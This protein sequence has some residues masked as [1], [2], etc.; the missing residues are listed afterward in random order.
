MKK[1]F[2]FAAMLAMAASCSVSEINPIKEIGKV[3]TIAPEITASYENNGTKTTI[4]TDDEGVGTIWWKPADEI[5]VFY[6][7]T[8]THYVSK[9]K[10]N[11]TTV[12]FGTT[13]IIGS[14]ESAQ[15]NIWGLYPYNEDAVCD[16]ES[17]ITTISAIQKGV[18]GTFDDD[19][20]TSLAHSTSTVMTFYNVLGGIKFS[21]LREDIKKITFK[22]N[23]DE[24]IAG[25]VK[26]EMDANGKPAAEVTEGEKTIIL[27]PKEGTTFAKNTNY[28]IVLLPTVLS[29]GFTMTFET[30][31]A[32]GTFEYTAKSIEI[33][34]SVF[35]KKENLDTYASFENIDY[36]ATPF[37]ISS[38]GSTSVAL[39]K[40]GTPYDITLEYRKGKGSWGAYTIGNSI[41]LGDGEYVQF[42]AGEGGND[43]FSKTLS[44][45]TGYDRINRYSFKS[46]GSGH[47]SV[48][49]NIMSLLDQNMERLSLGKGCFQQ[50]FSKCSHLLDASNL[51]LPA[52]NLDEVCYA[53]MFSGCSSLQTTPELP[54]ANLAEWCYSDMFD[55]CT[56]LQTAP[57]LPATNLASNCYSQMFDGC[58]SLQ[59]APELPATNLAESCYSEMFHGCTSLQTAPELPATTLA[60]Y[61]YSSMFSGCTSLQTAPELPSTNLAYGCYS[62]MFSGCTSLQTAPEL[63]AT[64]LAD[65]CYSSMFRLCSNLETV[66]ELPVTNLVVGCYSSMFN[67]CTSLQTAPELPATNLASHCYSGMFSDC[68]GLQTA[69]ELPST[70]LVVGCYRSMFSGCSSLQTAPELPAIDLDNDCYSKMFSECTG[71]TQAPELPATILAGGCY[72]SMFSGCASLQTAPELPATILDQE[73]YYKMFSGCYKLNYVEAM[74]ETTPSDTY[75]WNW[76][77]GVSSAG[78]F[79][80]SKNAT[81]DVTGPNGIPEGWTIQIQGETNITLDKTEAILVI[82][83]IINLTATVSP[84]D[85]PDKTVTWSSNDETIATVEDGVVTAIMVGS[86]TITAKSGD[87]TATC[88]ITV[89]AGETT[90]PFTI[91]SVGSTSISI[92]EADFPYSIT[93]EYRKGEGSWSA[94]NIGSTISLSDG[95]KVQFIAGLGGNANFSR[96]NK[97]HYKVVVSGS[98]TAKVSGNIM[99]LLEKTGDKSTVPNYAFNH[100]F[101]DCNKLIDASR[102]ELPATNL[103]AG[104][105]GSMFSGC[106]SL[107]TA[108]EL[109]A[110]TLADYCYISMFSVCTSLQTAPELPATNLASGCYSSMFYGC[111]SLQTTPEL[112]AT[113]LAE[114]CYHS[115]FT[116]CTS[117]QTAPEILPA[118][119]LT[120][121]CYHAMFRLCSNLKTVPKLPATNLASNCYSYMFDGCTSLQ[122]APA[123]PATTLADWCYR[124]MFSGCASLQTAPEL[125]ATNLTELCYYEM[126]SGCSKL[127]YVKAMFE[128]TPSDIYTWNWLAGVSSTGTFVK[129]KN[130]TWDVTGP[131]GIPE[132]WTVQTAE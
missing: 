89:K 33:K 1:V 81:W 44:Y 58:T 51:K 82:G 6:G 48:S 84:D 124:S 42:R 105:Y 108:P 7:T 43:N 68:S 47:I 41:D 98:G 24:D 63:P 14:T 127:N 102:L 126:F 18:A 29:K 110:T 45:V 103:A 121:G 65:Y 12:A 130:A 5:N 111:T 59:T 25:K 21:L 46:T 101:S 74:F 92:I 85:A 104:C 75:T 73:C 36:S 53:G 93:L 79:V 50:L 49:G 40:E 61:C 31:T 87:K 90:N 107:Q 71:L 123:L 77:A 117:L 39:T 132:G 30:E 72:D 131:N 106:T 54:A 22:G 2:L 66:P 23:N 115:M 96:P 83:E 69:P 76:L 55:G 13:D 52:T 118:T 26:L 32:I 97:N 11:A 4:T 88:A 70:N 91:T 37:T 112:P 129:S 34:R 27:T 78:T 109:P 19:I 17:V 122:T 10:E 64:T 8:S 95:E 15:E 16:G 116:G 128:T 99:S 125:P 86:A 100:L 3:T 113:T 80:K 57:E 28:Y 67:G 56:S 9:N 35:S 20:F 119:N 114:D 38:I 120:G 94:Y 62:S 60:D